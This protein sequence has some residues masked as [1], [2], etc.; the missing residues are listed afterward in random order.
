MDAAVIPIR[1]G[2]RS[3]VI[4]PVTPE[5]DERLAA[6]SA[7]GD[8]RAYEELVVRHQRLILRIVWARGAWSQEDAEDLAQETFVRAWERLDT[9]DPSRPFK[10]WIARIAGNLAIDRHRA[11]SRRPRT[12]DIDE[13]GST[14]AAK[15]PGPAAATIENE[16]QRELL[17]RL[18]ELPEHYRQ[19]IVLRFLEELSYEE[20]AELLDLPMGSV[21][22]RIFRG[23]EMLRQRLRPDIVEGEA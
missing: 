23:R 2:A 15:E 13:M 1:S 17:T 4:E 12:T 5:T 10:A 20:I 6:R 3:A 14:L 21:K 11:E 16:Q 19:V 7:R 9:Y 18:R 22:T 8:L